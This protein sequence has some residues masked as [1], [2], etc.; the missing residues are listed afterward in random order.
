MFLCKGE[1]VD[2]IPLSSTTK[3]DKSIYNQNIKLSK[4][5]LSTFLSTF[6]L[7]LISQYVSRG[8]LRGAASE[9]Y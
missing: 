6:L 5:I 8:R 4:K 3:H 2:S 1:V 7:T 9:V